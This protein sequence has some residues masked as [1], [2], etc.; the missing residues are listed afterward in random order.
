MNIL[1]TVFSK[2]NKDKVYYPNSVL[3]TLPI[4]NCKGNS[5]TGD[6]VEFSIAFAS[7]DKIY[8]LKEGIKRLVN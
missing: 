2:L 4:S 3:S 7:V 8:A 5:D 1:T 6:V